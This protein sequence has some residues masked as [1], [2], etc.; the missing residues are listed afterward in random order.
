MKNSANMVIVISLLFCV[1]SFANAMQNKSVDSAKPV[2]TLSDN[3]RIWTAIEGLRKTM[4][5]H[6]ALSDQQY[7]ML[8][9]R[10]QALEASVRRISLE[11]RKAAN[12]MVA[13]VPAHAP[14]SFTHYYQRKTT[15]PRPSAPNPLCEQ[16]GSVNQQPSVS[17]PLYE[18]KG[19]HQP[20]AQAAAPASTKISESQQDDGGWYGARPSTSDDDGMN[21]EKS[22]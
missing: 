10:M 2:K 13:P 16:T 17:N 20:S 8:I 11:Q 5:D 21:V 6:I 19:N 7:K 15:P 3:E 14:H 4:Q 22:E 18:S 9:M 1:Y 12:G